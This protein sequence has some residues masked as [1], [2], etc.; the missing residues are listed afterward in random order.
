MNI[1]SLT[2]AIIS[3]ACIMMA[4]GCS[5]GGNLNGRSTPQAQKA[6]APGFHLD[7]ETVPDVSPPFPDG[8]L[9]PPGPVAISG[10]PVA[11]LADFDKQL[12]NFLVRWQIPGCAVA[13]A[14]H[15]QLV[16]ARGFGWQDV[17]QHR[18]TQPD[19]LCR[20][21]SVSKALTT[22]AVL[23]LCQDGKLTLSTRALPLL[24][25]PP[26]PDIK[27]QDPRFNDITVRE[28]LEYTGGWNRELNQDPMFVPEVGRASEL[29]SP[30]LRPTPDVAIRY[31]LRRPLDFDPGTDFAYSNL[32][33]AILGRVIGKISG[34]SYYDYTRSN[35]LEPMGIVGMRLGRTLVAAPGEMTYY[36]YPGQESAR[37]VFPNY[38]R[39]V[40]LPYGGDFALEANEAD[41]G[42]I[43]SAPELAR[44]MCCLFGDRGP[45]PL[46][47]SWLRQMV[48][49]PN[50]TKWEGT[51]T[52]FAQGFEVETRPAFIA[53]EQSGKRKAGEVQ[54]AP[55]DSGDVVICKRGSFAGSMAYVGRDGNGTTVAYVA[56]S[57]P[58]EP[59]PCERQLIGLL[60]QAA[61]GYNPT[62]GSDL[63][64][65]FR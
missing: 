6:A 16:Y 19:S 39:K 50:I 56:N 65:K 15:G 24:K 52:Y 20:I 29:L 28:L 64:A 22:V 47:K 11:G 51:A 40:P 14:K 32:E 1:Q 57:R 59:D 30:T 37:S 3:I 60:W 38:A 61:R 18:L 55:Q 46:T 43:A 25:Y 26:M 5:A 21:A 33:Y 23:K 17:R 45:G 13:I 4:T 31:A 62:E 49:R 10:M 8:R 44:F 9:I 53:A 48:S 27:D 41:S 7:P 58:E 63:F 54:K 34:Q 35:I 42:W 2:I 12:S 36:P